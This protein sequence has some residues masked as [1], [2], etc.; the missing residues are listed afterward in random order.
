MPANLAV[1][2]RDS[3]TGCEVKLVPHSL[4]KFDPEVVSAPQLGQL[5]DHASPSQER[6]VPHSHLESSAI[7]NQQSAISILNQQSAI[8]NQQP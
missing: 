5:I 7:R 8:S 1:F 4:Q 3:D 6:R 2:T